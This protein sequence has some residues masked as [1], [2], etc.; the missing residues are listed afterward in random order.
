MAITERSPERTGAK[1]GRVEAAATD[2][3]QYKRATST[4]ENVRERALKEGVGALGLADLNPAVQGA[5]VLSLGGRLA[6]LHHHTTTHGVERIR[7]DTGHG[8]HTLGD[9]PGDDERRL[10]RVRQHALRGIEETEVRSSVDD[11]TLHGHDETSVQ[12]ERTVGLEDLHE[13]V[14]QTGELTAAL[15]AHIGGQTRTREVERVDEAQRGGTGRTAGRQ[16]TAEVSPELRLLVH[17]AQEHLLVF[18]LEREVQRLCREVTDHVGEVTP[19]ET[20]EALLSRD[21]HEAVDDTCAIW[22]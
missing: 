14:A 8:G 19:P 21:T 2:T 20:D 13:T 16:V 9:H 3:H 18:I 15:L 10:L 22:R 1:A 17:A 7:D 5:L 11:N 4:T 12:T 6:R